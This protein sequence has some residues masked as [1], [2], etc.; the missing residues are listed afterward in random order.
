MPAPARVFVHRSSDP[1]APKFSIHH[2]ASGA[3]TEQDEVWLV[4]A[5]F[6]V[7]DSGRY[8][9]L[10]DHRRTVH[11]GV[12]GT[13]VEGPPRGA[14]HCNCPVRYKPTEDGYFLNEDYRPVHTAEVVHLVGGT[15]YVPREDR[16]L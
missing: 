12:F 7:S 10:L 8:R 15:V 16:W 2:L 4:D 14:Q 3:V 13:L 6:E 11:A 1:R 5:F 9:A